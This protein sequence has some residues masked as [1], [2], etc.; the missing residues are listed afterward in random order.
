[1]VDQPINELFSRFRVDNVLAEAGYRKAML[2]AKSHY[3]NFPVVSFL[4][5]KELRNDVAIL[6]WFGR[7][8]DDIADE[9][10]FSPDER[11]E[12]LNS[13]EKSFLQ[14]LNQEPVTAFDAA[15]KKT[16]LKHNLNP[17]LFL[18]LLSAF[19]QDIT[20]HRYATL[21]ELLD[22]ARRSAD[23]VGRLML[24]LYHIDSP[25][26]LMASDAV[27][28]GLQLVNFAQ[29]ISIDHNKG[30]I[31]IPGE[32]ME[33]YGITEKDFERGKDSEKFSMMLRDFCSVP[34]TLLDK[35]GDILPHL[36]GLFKLEIAW[37][38][39]G[40]LEILDKL[41]K[42]N[43]CIFNERPKL[44]YFGFIH[45]LLRSFFYARAQRKRNREK[46]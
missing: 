39:L 38:I 24:G 22:Y 2:L 3:E 43:F 13:F 11:L 45:L 18:D 29:D 28:T 26:A 5:K 32:Y 31:Y 6:Y 19:R 23:P 20:R 8:A 30:R 27:C 14:M 41:R 40:G 44:N 46:E 21:E 12:R 16:M 37:T 33:V 36:S 10:K 17:K 1:M 25:E 15:L 4:I 34:R 9:G 7:T 35:G 42:S